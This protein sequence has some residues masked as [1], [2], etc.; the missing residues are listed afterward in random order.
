M[1]TATLSWAPALSFASEPAQGDLLKDFV[2]RLKDFV[3][4]ARHFALR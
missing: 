2:G 1:A 4:R 3:G